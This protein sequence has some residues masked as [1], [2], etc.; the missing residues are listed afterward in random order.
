MHN[1]TF[2]LNKLTDSQRQLQIDRF[3]A[4]HNHRQLTQRVQYTKMSHKLQNYLTHKIEC[5]LD[6]TDRSHTYRILDLYFSYVD[7]RRAFV[8]V[9]CHTESDASEAIYLL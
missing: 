7:L 1:K 6:E 9:I 5:Y 4:Y 2:W 8:V 3:L